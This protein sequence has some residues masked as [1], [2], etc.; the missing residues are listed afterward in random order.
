MA[1]SNSKLGYVEAV[2]K[3]G[4]GAECCR[5]LGAGASGF[6]CMKNTSVKKLLDQR[7]AL[8][9][10]AAQADNCD[11]MDPDVDLVTVDIPE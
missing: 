3:I 1:T 8:K 4:Q 9:T 7:A 2:C 5:Y 6:C 10:M 11:G